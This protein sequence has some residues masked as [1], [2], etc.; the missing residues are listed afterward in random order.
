MAFFGLTGLGSQSPFE[1]A[2]ETPLHV[3]DTADFQNAFMQTYQSG[4][5]MYSESEEEVESAQ[6][7][8]QTATLSCD[9]LSVMLQYL[10]QCPKGVNNV[11]LSTQTLVRDGFVE[12]QGQRIG[13]SAF[14]KLMELLKTRAQELEQRKNQATYLKDGLQSREFVSNNELRANLVKHTRMARDPKDKQLVAMTDAHTFGWLPPTIVAVRKPT[15]SCEETKYASAMV[16]AGV[17][18]Y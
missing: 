14:L 11:P 18:Y 9:Q 6:H 16:K 8:L 17:Y 1:V 10:Y 13:L 7:T 4:F 12:F 5:T 15:K 3:F 2:K